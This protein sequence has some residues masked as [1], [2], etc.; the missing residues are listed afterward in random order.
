MGGDGEGYARS[1]LVLDWDMLE[2]EARRDDHID[3]L[4][5]WIGELVA[6]WMLETE[7]EGDGDT[8]PT[9]RIGHTESLALGRIR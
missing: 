8:E 9:A 3:L 4:A 7:T 1:G 5:S 2:I 6:L